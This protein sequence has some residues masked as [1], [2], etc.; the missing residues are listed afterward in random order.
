M[1]LRE[2]P[3][4][5]CRLTVWC[6]QR[7]AN[8]TA[9]SSRRFASSDASAAQA[10]PADLQELESQS[11]FT[12]I[13]YPVEKIRAYDPVKNAQGRKRELPPSRYVSRSIVGPF[14]SERFAN[15]YKIPISISTIQSRTSPPSPTSSI[16]RPLFSRVRARPVLANATR[17]DLPVD[18]PSRPNDPRLRTH[19][20]RDS[21]GTQGGPSPIVGRLVAISQGQTEAWAPRAWGKAAAVG[22]R[23]HLARHP[24]DKGGDGA[25]YGQGSHRGISVPPRG[26]H[27]APVHHR[28]EAA[29][30]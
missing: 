25:Q 9:I 27:D 29:G 21:E 14:R 18:H 12:N 30:P 1:A 28:G 22:E 17:A 2:L 13:E 23:F 6:P 19:A 11:S 7:V 4:S 10:A 5:L 15:F 26:G 24:G 8:T 16:L 3:R 20:A